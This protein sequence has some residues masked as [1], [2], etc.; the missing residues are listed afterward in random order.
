MV[1]PT[2][3]PVQP[4]PGLQSAADD[5]QASSE[6]PSDEPPSPSEGASED[7]TALTPTTTPVPSPADAQPVAS[8]PRPAPGAQTPAMA[9]DSA[10]YDPTDAIAD[11]ALPDKPSARQTEVDPV[12]APPPPPQIEPEPEPEPEVDPR[13]QTYLRVEEADA[14]D[15]EN[16]ESTYIGRLDAEA[17]DL[18]QATVTSEHAGRPTPP[19]EG[20]PVDD[21]RPAI[22]Q[23]EGNPDGSLGDAPAAGTPVATP[24]PPRSGGGIDGDGPGKGSPDIGT[25]T[26]GGAP[27]PTGRRAQAAISAEQTGASAAGRQG[28]KSSK[29]PD[30]M[31]ALRRA[32]WWSPAVVRVVRPARDATPA[33]APVTAPL[34]TQGTERAPEPRPDTQD[35]RGGTEQ[36]VDVDEP[37]PESLDEVSDTDSGEADPIEEVEEEQPPVESVA[38]LREAMGWGGINRARLTPKRS[39]SGTA[40]AD[41]SRQTSAQTVAE[42]LLFD[43]LAVVDAHATPRGR[44]RARVDEKILKKWREMDLSLH[45]RALGIQGDVTVVV[46]IRASGK[47]LDKTLIRSS[48]HH[49]LDAMA[50]DAVPRRLPRFPNEL[51]VPTMFHRYTFR[52]R[53]PMIVGGSASP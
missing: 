37:T 31:L 52:Y 30:N 14:V 20:V 36:P 45:E 4:E 53:N 34:P 29:N 22:E 49:S 17:V 10:G 1:Q 50:L 35:D 6:G 9:D 25:H 39:V 41:S 3:R 21:G 24:T 46:H 26:A 16:L 42:D 48:G 38:D 27:A 44:Y 28:T 12:E 40:S 43:R 47:V 51:S 32:T 19:V 18:R 23:L 33:E 7:P 8:T 11:A 15:T 5:A 13:W 2:E